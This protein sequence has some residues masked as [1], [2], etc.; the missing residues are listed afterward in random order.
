MPRLRRILALAG[1]EAL[2]ASLAACAPEAA[3]PVELTAGSCVADSWNGG[4]FRST[5]VDC[6]SP[7]LFD[8]VAS[9][10]EWS[11]IP[12]ALQ[13][14]EADARA[15]YERLVRAD[16]ADEV[17]TA[18]HDWADAGCA[19][20]FDA[21]LGFD[22]VAVD[23]LDGSTLGL[24]VH[25]SWQLVTALSTGEQFARGD[26][27]TVCAVA[28]PDSDG[29]LAEVAHPAGTTV[30]ALAGPGLPL[31]S[32]ECFDLASDGGRST[33]PC[34]QP[35]RGQVI[36]DVDARAALGEGWVADVDPSTGRSRDYGAADEACAAVLDQLLP[37]GA[38][39][40]GR[41]SWADLRPV[42]GWVGFDGTVGDA[43]YPISCAVITD[44]PEHLL[45]ADLWG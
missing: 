2:V 28:W 42:E 38:L 25:A 22:R 31:A 12:A 39:G 37:D 44:D 45:D 16:P 5:V 34:T 26:R 6:S 7:H 41:Q 30:A 29:S 35:H 4:P 21:L 27:T 1:A 32:R 20:A 10:G 23:G 13:E 36:V 8:V 19:T 17:A 43:R 40:D 18:F 11:G 33:V 9:L 24:R 3:E 14:T 15:L